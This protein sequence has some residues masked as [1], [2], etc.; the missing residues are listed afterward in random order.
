M[1]E[2]STMSRDRTL[3]NGKS[4]GISW[5]FDEPADWTSFGGLRIRLFLEEACD[6]RIMLIIPSENEDVEGIDYYS[7]PIKL[8]WEG[9]TDWDIPLRELGAARSPISR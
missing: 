8:D 9:W 4:G 1:D 2:D 3:A 5:T 7:M 6:S